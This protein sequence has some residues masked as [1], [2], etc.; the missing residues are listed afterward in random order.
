MEEFFQEIE[1]LLKKKKTKKEVFFWSL[2]VHLI[3]V[4][5]H[6]FSDGNGRVARLLEKW[7]LAEKLGKEF[8][9]LESEK[10]YWENLKDYYESLR[11]GVNYWE[12]DFKKAKRFLKL[13][14]IKS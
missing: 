12:V 8:W 1:K 9:F 3:F 13:K 7:F 6:P 2:W 4:L 5:I 14:K 10:F 11:L